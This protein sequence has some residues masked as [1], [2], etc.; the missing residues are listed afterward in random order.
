MSFGSVILIIF[1]VLLGIFMIYEGYSLVRLIID[2]IKHKSSHE[3]EE[4]SHEVD[5]S[6]D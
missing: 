4:A 1:M 6:E 5:S 2:K 3:K